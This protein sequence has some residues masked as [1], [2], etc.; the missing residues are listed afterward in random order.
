MTDYTDLIAR[1]EEHIERKG[2][3]DCWP[4]NGR[5]LKKDGR[6]LLWLNKKN[7]TAPRV[8]WFVH[9]GRWPEDD[10]FVCHSCDN[11]NCVNPSHLWL[12]TNKDNIQDAANKGRM[13]GQSKPTHVIGT[14]HGMSKLTEN[15]VASAR[16]E[17][18]EGG[19]SIRNLA[20][21]YGVTFEPMRL[22]LK[23]KGW[24]HV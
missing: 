12:G 18:A 19:I 8:S 15:A 23:G 16:K 11:P 5:T 9:N 7:V 4:W 14:K 3:D 17:Y 20:K 6:G 24:K 10:V 2:V 13:F 22:A 21:K 1:F